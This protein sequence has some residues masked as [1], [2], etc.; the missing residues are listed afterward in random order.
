M[1]KS[2]IIVLALTLT[3]LL[4]G[5]GYYVYTKNHTTTPTNE[6]PSSVYDLWTHWKSKNNKKYG[7]ED[8]YRL[9]V[10]YQNYQK[11]MNH[12]KNPSKTYNLGFTKFMDLTTEEFKAKYLST[13]VQTTVNHTKYLSTANLPSS[14]DWR[15]KGAVTGVKDQGQCGSCW[16]F[17]TTGS[18]E[19]LSFLS[20]KG[21]QSFSEQQLVDCSTSEGNQGCNGGLMDYGFT[22]VESNG[23]TTEDA[24]PYTAVDGTCSATGGAFRIGGYTDVPQGDV[25]QLAAAVVQQP[26]SIAVDAENWQLYSSGVFSDCDTNLD[27]GVL[28][29][30]YTSDAWIVKNSWAESWGENGYIR[31]ARGNT[32]GLANSASYP[33]A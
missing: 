11:V 19:G 9:S 26:V 1:N 16:A 14:V 7:T 31:L 5:L 22:Y 10:F 8:Q 25:N 28:L 27:H 3:A 13:K 21:L 4:T 29:V 20:G 18:L 30:G 17:S 24:Y 23:I 6:I 2:T 15:T 33:T 32:C 12:Q